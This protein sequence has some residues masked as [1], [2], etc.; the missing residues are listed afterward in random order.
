MF[1]SD[2]EFKEIMSGNKQVLDEVL[3]RIYN[4]AVEDALCRIP[5]VVVSYTQKNA[6]IKM[7]L[8]E[9]YKDNPDFKG[10]EGM[11]QQVVKEIE[12]KTPEKTYEELFA[13]AIP[14]IKERIVE[15]KTNTGIAQAK[16]NAAINLTGNGVL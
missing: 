3:A 2:S 5:S 7:A 4:K 12:G 11:V 10:H 13:M 16:D 1:L 15:Y 9:M 6:A 14:I 8:G